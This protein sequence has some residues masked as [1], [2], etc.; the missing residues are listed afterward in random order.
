MLKST[1]YK[2][3]KKV[4]KLSAR[5]RQNAYFM[6]P[7]TGKSITSLA[8]VDQK[9]RRKNKQFLVLVVCPKNIIGSWEDEIATH[10][11]RA[12]VQIHLK[13]EIGE[14]PK[15]AQYHFVI[16]NYEQI[17]SKIDEYADLGW[18]YIILDESHRIKNRKAKTTKS[19]WHLDAPY[20]TILSGTPITKDEIDL[21]AQYKWLNQSIGGNSFKLFEKEALTKVRV[22]DYFIVKPNK[23]RIK[24]FMNRASKFTH[25][26][27]L[28]D[29]A[30][31]PPMSN[32]P[33]NL[34]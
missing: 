6:E 3:Q 18:D 11:T 24:P 27:K 17:R 16:T 29:I 2:A 13:Q 26:L 34:S 28:E 7:G 20:K 22:G 12:S 19:V 25:R 30:E 33:V 21:W 10:L 15:E 23:S 14:L 31:I 4:V 1:L 5:K 8:D 9:Q 32:I